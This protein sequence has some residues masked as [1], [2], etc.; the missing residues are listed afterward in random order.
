MLPIREEY[1]RLL[2]TGMAYEW[3][4]QLTGNYINDEE[5]WKIIYEQLKIYRNFK[6]TDDIG[7]N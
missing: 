5:E 2:Q 6:S 1:D 3:Y 4:P 7:W